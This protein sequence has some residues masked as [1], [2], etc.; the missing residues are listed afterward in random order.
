MNGDILS[1]YQDKL[2]GL[3]TPAIGLE[4]LYIIVIVLL[5]LL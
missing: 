3:L 2:A 5:S 1:F 4:P